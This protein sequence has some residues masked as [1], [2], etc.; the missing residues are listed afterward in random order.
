MVQLTYWSS[1]WTPR[2]TGNNG[3]SSGKFNLRYRDRRAEAFDPAQRSNRF[4]IRLIKRGRTGGKLDSNQA[5]EDA[6]RL[7]AAERHAPAGSTGQAEHR[8]APD[9]LL[10][11]RNT[12]RSEAV[13]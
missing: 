1:T 5:D 8:P 10:R 2:R 3:Q 13:R 9:S 4:E 7:A 11:A 12:N 6:F